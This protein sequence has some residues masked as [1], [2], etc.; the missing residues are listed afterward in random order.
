M[1]LP[2]NIFLGSELGM[3]AKVATCSG[4]GVEA[5]VA[6]GSESGMAATVSLCSRLG[7]EAYVFPPP[8]LAVQVGCVALRQLEPIAVVHLQVV[9]MLPPPIFNTAMASVPDIA[10]RPVANKPIHMIILFRIGS[11]FLYVNECLRSPFS[12]PRKP[13]KIS[14]ISDISSC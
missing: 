8:I 11:P 6:I 5:K 1:L 13:G 12:L 14:T 4:L 3:E 9:E 2:T 10:I 7:A